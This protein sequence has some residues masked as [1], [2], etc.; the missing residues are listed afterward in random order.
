MEFRTINTGKLSFKSPVSWEKEKAD[1]Y[2]NPDCVVT[3][4]KGEE[5]LIN[6]VMFPTRTNLDD[7]KIFMEDAISDDGGV[8]LESDFTVISGKSAIKTHANM[9]TPD[10]NFDI[11]NYV[12]IENGNIYIFE[13]RTVEASLEP[14]SEFK[15]MIKTLKLK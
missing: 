12:F 6:V 13:L 3:L 4:S 2:N 11:Y 10:I 8:I 1:T 5:N 15:D 7:Y 9:D 14:V